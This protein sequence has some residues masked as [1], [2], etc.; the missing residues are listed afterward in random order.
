M[1]P[2]NELMLREMQSQ[3]ADL[4]TALIELRGQAAGLGVARPSK[5]VLAG[6][7]DSGFA[8]AEIGRASCRER[9]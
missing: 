8:A 3:P 5:V 2:V 9:V 1:G 6:S 7:G 4:A